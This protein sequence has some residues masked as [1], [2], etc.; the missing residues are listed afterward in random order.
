[1]GNGGD[2]FLRF[3]KEIAYSHHER[4]DGGGY[5]QGLAGDAIPLSARLMA[6]AGDTLTPARRTLGRA[7]CPAV[8]EQGKQDVSING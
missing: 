6:V 3:A 5:P 8:A 7:R 2:S 4:W 1:M